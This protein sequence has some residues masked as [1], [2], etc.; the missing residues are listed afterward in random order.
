MHPAEKIIVRDRMTCK[1]I[2]EVIVAADILRKRSGT[3][4]T[5]EE[6]FGYSPTGELFM[7]GEWFAQAK[8]VLR[9]EGR[10]INARHRG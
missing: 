6:I 2:C 3:A 5:A 10:L 9:A 4:P 1:E 7:L 8:H